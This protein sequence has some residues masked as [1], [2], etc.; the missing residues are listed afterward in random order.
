MINEHTQYHIKIKGH[1]DTRWQEWFD[2]LT[3]I[4]GDDGNTLLTGPVADQA[5]LYGLLR[6]VRD[7]GLALLSVNCDETGQNTGVG[8]GTVLQN[9]NKSE[10]KE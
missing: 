7:L 1:L 10:E 4:L 9:K 5:A 3:I 6:K 8:I 2:D